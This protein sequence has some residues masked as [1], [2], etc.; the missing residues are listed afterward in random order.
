MISTAA[1]LTTNIDGEACQGEIWILTCTGR[2]H[3]HRWTLEMEGSEPIMMTYT[4]RQSVPGTNHKGPYNFTL[5]S[6]SNDWFES[7]VSTVLTT[8]LNNTVAK[9]VDTQS[10]AQPVTIRIAGSI[11]ITIAIIMESLLLLIT[12]ILCCSMHGIAS[13]N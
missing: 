5:V 12:G 10:E 2:S 9:C 8:A 3:T 1:I 6:V 13:N 4:A 7:I 11:L